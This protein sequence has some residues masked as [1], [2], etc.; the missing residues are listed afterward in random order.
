[1]LS[2]IDKIRTGYLWDFPGGIHP[3]ENKVQ[4]TQTPLVE[5]RLAHEY[6]LPLKQHIGKSGDLLVQVGD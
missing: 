6:V 4:S 5:A 2:L 1:M 3:P